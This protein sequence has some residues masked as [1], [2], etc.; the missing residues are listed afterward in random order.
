MRKILLIIP[1]T[2]LFSAIPLWSQY[3]DDYEPFGPL[4]LHYDSPADV[5]ERALVIGN[6]TLGGTIYGGTDEDVISLNDITLWT[7]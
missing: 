1:L 7:G 6:G 3:L 5:F 4:T 2:F